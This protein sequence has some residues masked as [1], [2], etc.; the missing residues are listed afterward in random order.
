MRREKRKEKR[1][2]LH[3]YSFLFRLWKT[4]FNQHDVLTL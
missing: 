4:S 2:S 1:I 3:H